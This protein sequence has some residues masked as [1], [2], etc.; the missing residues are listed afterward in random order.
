MMGAKLIIIAGPQQGTTL[1]LIE[2]EMLMGREPS[3]WLWIADSAISRRHCVIRKEADQFKIVDL[4]SH[5]GTFVNDVPVQERILQE[6][7]R[8]A[9]GDSLLLFIRQEF[10]TASSQG[11]AQ[12]DE[13]LLIAKSTI[14]L[15]IQDGVY[16]HP[17]KLPAERPL[18]EQIAKGFSGLLRFSNALNSIL[19]LE[20]LEQTLM[21]LL[22]EMIPAQ[23]GIIVFKEQNSEE[24]SYKHPRDRLAGQIPR[25]AVSQT[26]LNRVLV[27]NV[28]ILSNDIK[29]DQALLSAKSL[30]ASDVNSLLAVPLAIR[31]RVLGAIYMDT[32]E[33]SAS[34]NEDH[35]ELSTAAAAITA[36]AIENLRH[37]E[38]LKNENS[39]LQAEI[40]LEHNMIGESLRMREVYKMI[41][42]VGPADSTVLIR[43]ESGTGKELVARAVYKNSTRSGNPFVAINCAALPE[44]L[45]ESELF[46]YEKGAFTGATNQKKGKLEVA[47]TGTVFLDEIAELSP[48]LQAKLLRV[49]QE[50]EFERI[51]GV[52]PINIDV[53]FIAATNK[54]LEEAITQGTF[55]QDLYYRLNVVSITMPPLR[56]RKEDIPLLATYFTSKH[57]KKSKRRVLGVSSQ[58]RACLMSYDWPGNIRELENAIERAVVLGTVDFILP[59]D[60]PESL[61]DSQ[62]QKNPGAIPFY[63]AVRD[64]KK[65]IILKALESSNGNYTEAARL[66]GVHPNNL[67]RLIRTL[68][69]KRASKN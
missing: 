33:L 5:N 18:A 63:D 17:E 64:S 22:F 31:N 45:L 51:G 20:E 15:R 46:G 32:T 4:E 66:L 61:F 52:R 36:M 16:F 42:R 11:V 40:N 27:E 68:D 57:A 62:E 9:I 39:R 37:L 21:D 50:H 34:F 69:I 48:T 29:K 19:S 28:A 35:L 30:S 58:A 2:Q 1:E 26:I 8:I 60:L 54:N 7:D 59:E 12:P 14:E 56:E 49:L 67:H 53:R 13:G 65:Q 44:T 25:F 24:L 55:R 23:R 43:G 6:G 41:G 38:W 47:D 10:E 3:N